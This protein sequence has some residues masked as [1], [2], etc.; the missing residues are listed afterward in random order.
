MASI[1]PNRL[2][3]VISKLA[4]LELE[5]DAMDRLSEMEA[6]VRVV[7]VG[8]FTEAA[9]RLNVSKSAISKY[10]AA[11]EGRL[12]ARL[13]NRTT[14][15]VS[16]T[17]IG[18]AYYDRA[19]RILAEA[20]EAD[21]MAAS[22]QGVPQGELRISAPLTFGVNHVA[23]AVTTFLRRYAEISVHLT[24]DDMVVDLVSGGFDLAIRIGN[25]PDS[26]LMARK[27]ATVR[28]TFVASADYLAK[29]GT[30]ATAQDLND[31]QL[32]HYSYLATGNLWRL[33]TPAG[34]ERQI[35]AGGRLT[36][37]NGAALTAAAERGLGIAMS[38]AFICGPAL[39]TGDLVEIELDAM[40]EPLG[41]YAIYP[42]GRY[43]P[44]KVRVMIDFLAERFSSIGPDW[45]CTPQD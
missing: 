32:L 12:G 45:S 18:L 30:P 31:H 3:S 7:D 42:A 33:R 34:A 11:L 14:R 26:S 10:V 36:M 40:P 27:L 37:N 29:H 23:P 2:Q 41:I 5:T 25:L 21:A 39:A 43:P 38:P 28:S 13:L 16:P 17:E 4:I 15:R 24:F 22:M 19:T 44:P 6:F 35:R 1:L 20:E 9:R 8:G